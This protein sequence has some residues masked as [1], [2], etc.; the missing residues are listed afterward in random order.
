MC[1]PRPADRL[2]MTYGLSSQ[3]FIGV[4]LPAVR[5]NI[6][7]LPGAAMTA[8]HGV[9]AKGFES[10]AGRYRFCYSLPNKD[11]VN[12]ARRIV[13]KR[14]RSVVIEEPH[15]ARVDANQ[16]CACLYRLNVDGYEACPS[17]H[18]SYVYV[19]IHGCYRSFTKLLEV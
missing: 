11:S 8:L 1:M 5:K 4:A 13:V 2:C 10:S 12:H 9:D 6:E 15:C 18:L 7:E 14:Q 3:D 16:V 17:D 19:C